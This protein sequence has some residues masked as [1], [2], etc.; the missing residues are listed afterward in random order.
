VRTLQSPLQSADDGFGPRQFGLVPPMNPFSYAIDTNIKRFQNLLE[1]SV[2][3]TERR[4]IQGLLADEKAKAAL[5][6]S[7]PKKEYAERASA[8]PISHTDGRGHRAPSPI[9][10]VAMLP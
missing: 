8:A 9:P 4:T 7:E 6:T 1:T 3:E 10:P 5:Q 2:N